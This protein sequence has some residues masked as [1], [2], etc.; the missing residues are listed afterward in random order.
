MATTTTPKTKYVPAIGRRKTSTAQVRLTAAEKTSVIVNDRSVNEYFP[1]SELFKTAMGALHTAENVAEYEVT[2][3][4]TGGGTHSQ[5]EA[6]RH[7]IAR[8]LIKIDEE[9]KTDLKKAG[10][11]K[12]DPRAKERRKFGL[13]KARKSAQWSKR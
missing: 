1:T 2:V 4:V 11:L 10:F 6:V 12:R 7:G 13:K 3:K 9:F 5:A 8:A